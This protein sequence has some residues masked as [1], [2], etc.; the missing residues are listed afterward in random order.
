MMPIGVCESSTSRRPF[1]QSSRFS[2]RSVSMKPGANVLM[3]TAG[4]NA[5]A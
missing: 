1:F 5:L 2:S 4:A 3:R